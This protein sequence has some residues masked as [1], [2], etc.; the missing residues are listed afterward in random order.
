VISMRDKENQ[1]QRAEDH[2]VPATSDGMP[3]YT[4]PLPSPDVAAPDDTA[5]PTLPPRHMID[6]PERPADNPADLHK[7]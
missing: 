4:D 5:R 2:A 6:A 3:P 7:R 1:I